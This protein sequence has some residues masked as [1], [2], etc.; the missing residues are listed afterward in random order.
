MNDVEIELKRR[1]AL[2]AEIINDDTKFIE[3]ILQGNGLRSPFPELSSPEMII[4]WAL[5]SDDKRKRK[6]EFVKEGLAQ[7]LICKDTL[8]LLSRKI[9]DELPLVVSTYTDYGKYPVASREKRIAFINFT[10]YYQNF[11]GYSANIRDIIDEYHDTFNLVCKQI[12][13][14]YEIDY[15]SMRSAVFTSHL[16]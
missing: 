12:D 8:L 3:K 13:S 15:I 1:A 2:L 10:R 16:K 14:N 5:E 6:S 4:R 11:I 7:W 9:L